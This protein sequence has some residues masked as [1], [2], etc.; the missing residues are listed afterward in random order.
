MAGLKT[1]SS[2]DAWRVVLRRGRLE[3][4]GGS[5]LRCGR[6]KMRFGRLKTRD[7]WGGFKPLP[8]RLKMHV[9]TTGGPPPGE[10]DAFEAIGAIID[11]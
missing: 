7:F 2:R 4:G 6:L 5:I 1:G 3:T 9:T 10:N 11:C 8:N